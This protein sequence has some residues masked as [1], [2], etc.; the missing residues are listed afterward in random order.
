[1]VDVPMPDGRQ[2]RDKINSLVSY[3]RRNPAQF[4][5]SDGT[6]FDVLMD[7]LGT[8]LNTRIEYYA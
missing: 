8:L 2:Y 1:M 4:P 6:G 7:A 3:A 5:G